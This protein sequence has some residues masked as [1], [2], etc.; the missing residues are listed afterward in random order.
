MDRQTVSQT[1]C[2]D[3]D[4]LTTTTK[5]HANYQPFTFLTAQF[6]PC[7]LGQVLA[8]LRSFFLQGDG[9]CSCH[10]DGILSVDGNVVFLFFF[11]WFRAVL[12]ICLESLHL[13]TFQNEIIY[14]SKFKLKNNINVVAT[15][16]GFSFRFVLRFLFDV[17]WLLLH[18]WCWCQWSASG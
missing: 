14:N 9:R 18:R 11:S 15:H 12:F 3:S 2:V 17:F 4:W 1:N 16:H 7:P 13:S 8:W 10:V 5:V 6:P